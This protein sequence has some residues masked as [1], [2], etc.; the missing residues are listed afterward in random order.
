LILAYVDSAFAARWGRYFR[1]HGWSVHLAATAAELRR[2]TRR[3]RPTA[4]VIDV[5]LPDESAALAAACLSDEQPETR[6]ALVG[7]RS[8]RDAIDPTEVGARAWF[9]RH[10]APESAFADLIDGRLASV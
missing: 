4:A 7:P 3:H 9:S 5:D 10:D 1:R 2:L 8:R 6:I